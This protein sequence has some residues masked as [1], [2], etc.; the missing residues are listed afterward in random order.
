MVSTHFHFNGFF[1]NMLYFFILS[2]FFRRFYLLTPTFIIEP[3]IIANDKSPVL[4]SIRQ[5]GV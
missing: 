3:K 2:Y 4:T 5:Y 1:P